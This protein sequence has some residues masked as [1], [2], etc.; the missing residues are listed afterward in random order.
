MFSGSKGLFY[1]AGEGQEYGEKF[2]KGSIK[3]KLDTRKGEISFKINGK[4]YGIAARDEKL[5]QRLWMAFSS[6]P[7]PG[8][9]KIGKMNIISY[10]K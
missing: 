2:S 10:Q 8:Y 6:V 9:F 4:D 7:N 3:M 5:K 1:S